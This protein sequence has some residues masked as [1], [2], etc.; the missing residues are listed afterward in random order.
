MF[1]K[2]G[3]EA[4]RA[5][6]DWALD[7]SEKLMR[8]EIE[9]IPDGTYTFEDYLD[10]DGIDKDRPVKIHVKITI[11]GQRHHRR[12]QRLGRAGQ[13][14]GQ[15]RAGRGAIPPPTAPCST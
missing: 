8:A 10:N 13:R 5:T 9:K 4:M 6:M 14:T 3:A 11:D 15:L 2:Y 1:E 12:L 7:Y